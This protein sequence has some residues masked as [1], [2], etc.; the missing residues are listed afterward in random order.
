LKRLLVHHSRLLM[1]R[2][3]SDMNVVKLL[4]RGDNDTRIM[5]I[6]TV[7]AMFMLCG[8]A[9]VGLRADVR[10]TC[11]RE[12]SSALRLL[13]D[14]GNATAEYCLG[15]MYEHGQE[16]VHDNQEAARLFKLASAQGIPLVARHR[17][18]SKQVARADAVFLNGDAR[19]T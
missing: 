8:A 13:A 7:T 16:V 3:N 1:H 9:G 17:S 6:S 14:A 12:Y 5:L 18:R 11:D 4:R 2:A 15:L 19:R 10:P